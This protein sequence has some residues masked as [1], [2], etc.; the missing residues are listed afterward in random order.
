MKR[1]IIAVLALML[2]SPFIL[3]GCGGTNEYL[4]E[5]EYEEEEVVVNFEY[6]GYGQ[7]TKFIGSDDLEEL[8]LS[9][10][11]D[12]AGNV[13]SVADDAFRNGLKNVKKVIIPNTTVGIGNG[14]FADNKNLEEI[15]FEDGSQ[16][17]AINEYTFSSLPNLKKFTIPSSVWIVRDNSFVMSGITEMI[18]NDNYPFRDGMLL[19]NYNGGIANGAI[20]VDPTLTTFTFPDDITN[21]GSYL[22]YGNQNI[23]TVDLN[24]VTQIGS[25]AFTDSSLTT[26]LNSEN[27]TYATIKAFENTPFINDINQEYIILG[28][29]LLKYNGTDTVINIPENVTS[30]GDYAFASDLIT[31]VNIHDGIT[32]IG[33]SFTECPN[34]ETVRFYRYIPPYGH[35]YFVSTAKF[36]VANVTGYE[37]NILFAYCE[38][39]ILSLDDLS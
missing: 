31:E 10:S 30:I 14:A 12:L 33:Y 2:L 11:P 20:Y 9:S 22:F 27:V 21:M 19:A 6:N 25:R 16:L 17:E 24:K 4:P 29:M 18:G 15:I 37:N 34:V 28:T 5:F 38:N 13:I 39:E 1:K 3:T 26:L 35:G 23:Q 7:I 36:Y 8:T 32:S